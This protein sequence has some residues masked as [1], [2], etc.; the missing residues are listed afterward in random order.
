MN[1]DQVEGRWEQMRA[2]VKKHWPKLTD[3]DLDR[4][5]GRKDRFLGKLE[6]RYGLAKEA[7]EQQ[8]HEWL[9]ALREHKT[10]GHRAGSA[11]SYFG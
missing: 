6:E 5:A 4:I 1:W 11:T 2:N 9:H 10:A 7:A 8:M 3:D